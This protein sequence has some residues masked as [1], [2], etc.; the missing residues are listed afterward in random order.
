[1]S[2]QAS[3]Q[4]KA[5]ERLQTGA[6]WDDFCDEL[7]KI[8]QDIVQ[9]ETAPQSLLDRAEGYRYLA[10]LTRAGLKS[11]LEPEA[12][13]DPCWIQPVGTDIKMGMDNPDNVY[14]SCRVNAKYSYRIRGKRNSVH[15]LGFGAQGGGY[16]RTGNLQTHGSLDA[17]NIELDDEGCFEII[18][19]VEEPAQGLWLPMA[20]DTNMLQ[21]RQTFGDRSTEVLPQLSIERIDG[22]GDVADFDPLIIDKALQATTAFVRGTAKVFANWTENFKAHTNELPR[23][24]P[25][26]AYAAG[27]DPKIAYYHSY[28]DIA[29][30]EALVVDFTPPECEYWNFQLAN[31]WLESL[32]YRRYTIHINHKTAQYNADGSVR[33]VLSH[34]DPGVAN[35]LN[36]TGHKQGTM[37][38]RWLGAKDHP[39]PVAKLVKLSEVKD[40]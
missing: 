26:V 7:K 22:E 9:A 33:A 28:F 3:K 13:E 5:E 15:F 35:W 24:D 19:S 6:S 34:S 14:L 18:A 25:D 27:G 11:F 30:D 40:A 1:M 32:D 38:V 37:C 20:N 36:I 2:A 10:R 39:T 8:G 4:A 12:A 29:E 23:F 16:G 21:A 17:S 31:Y